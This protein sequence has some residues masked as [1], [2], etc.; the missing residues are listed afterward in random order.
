MWINSPT[1]ERA[2]S[3]LASL[4]AEMM[5]SRRYR[6]SSRGARNRVGDS[7][8]EESSPCLVKIDTHREPSFIVP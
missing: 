5:R 8:K 7:G 3:R 4:L 1:A 2:M 6:S